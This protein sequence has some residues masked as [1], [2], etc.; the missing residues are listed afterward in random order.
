MRT[1][2]VDHSPKGDVLSV[3]DGQEICDFCVNQR[4]PVAWSYPAKDFSIGLQGSIG[5]W[6]ACDRC[7]DLIEAGNVAAL[8]DISFRQQ[9]KIIP[10][11]LASRVYVNAKA[12][13]EGFFANRTGPRESDADYRKRHGLKGVS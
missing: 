12:M 8:L 9:M 1:I 4:Q 5:D 2:T 10:E 13:L 11:S 7:S 3:P 6:A